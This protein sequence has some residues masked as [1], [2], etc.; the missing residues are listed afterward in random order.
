VP[1]GHGRLTPAR[2]A[3]HHWSSAPPHA[4]TASRPSPSSC[5]PCNYRATA[6]ARPRSYKTPLLSLARPSQPPPPAISAAG[7]LAFPLVPVTNP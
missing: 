6:S 1:R 2:A 4:A 7:E 5:R 3:F